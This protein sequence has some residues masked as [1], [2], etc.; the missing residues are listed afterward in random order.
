V[1]KDMA[2]HLREVPTHKEL[3]L[4]IRVPKTKI[5]IKKENP[6]NKYLI[7]GQNNKSSYF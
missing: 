2:H 7:A 5:D 4:W 3:K 1:V 6:V